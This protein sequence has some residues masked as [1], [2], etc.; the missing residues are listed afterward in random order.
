M[1]RLHVELPRPLRVMASQTDHDIFERAL[2]LLICPELVSPRHLVKLPRQKQ[3]SSSQFSEGNPTQMAVRN[4]QT[5][6]VFVLEM[7]TERTLTVCWSDPR[8]GH[9]GEQTWRFGFARDD[10]YCVIS[11]K[12]ISRGD[13]I[14][15]PRKT[16]K[17]P[18]SRDHMILA[19][20]ISAQGYGDSPSLK[21]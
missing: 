7:L 10:A 16:A 11:G 18:S 1:T 19:S 6:R 9:C 8:A 21:I 13:K 15:R 12:R 3:T 17:Y 20:E 2:I 5:C 14:F 4:T